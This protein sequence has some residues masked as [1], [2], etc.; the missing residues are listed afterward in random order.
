M[1]RQAAGSQQHDPRLNH[2]ILLYFLLLT[3]LYDMAFCNGQEHG[4]SDAGR[5]KV[6]SVGY[7][8]LFEMMIQYHSVD[9]Q[10]RMEKALRHV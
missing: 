6:H 1:E 2:S 7:K 3:N 8:A 4:H 9:D 10:Q 5:G